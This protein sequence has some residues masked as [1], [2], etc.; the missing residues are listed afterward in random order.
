[1]S[2]HLHNLSIEIAVASGAIGEGRP[3]A[4]PATVWD[5]DVINI[6]EEG[7]P[8]GHDHGIQAIGACLLHALNDKLHIHR[9]LLVDRSQDGAAA[10]DICDSDNTWLRNS[11]F[12][13]LISIFEI[14]I[15][16][17]IVSHLLCISSCL[18]EAFWYAKSAVV[19]I[20]SG[21]PKTALSWQISLAQLDSPTSPRAPICSC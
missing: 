15:M 16:L 19:F 21:F 10:L 6:G 1:M 8:L 5:D 14:V 2:V 9:E 4:E 18:A 13:H 20:C 7:V 17:Q 11:F 3:S 12:S